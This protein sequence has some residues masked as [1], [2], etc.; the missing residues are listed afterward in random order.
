[1]AIVDTSLNVL[2][3]TVHLRRVVLDFLLQVQVILRSFTS[4]HPGVS[5][6]LSRDGTVAKILELL[7]LPFEVSEFSL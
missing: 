6:I 1:M 5:F 4:L 7:E 2:M 3:D